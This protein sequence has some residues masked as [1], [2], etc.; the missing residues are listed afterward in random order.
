[1]NWKALLFAQENF[2]VTAVESVSAVAVACAA[3]EAGS[4]PK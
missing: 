3:D 2:L 1:M 4:V